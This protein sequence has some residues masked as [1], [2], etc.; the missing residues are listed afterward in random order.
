MISIFLTSLHSQ[1]G[2]TIQQPGYWAIPP[3]SSPAGMV[4]VTHASALSPQIQTQI[5]SQV[6]KIMIVVGKQAAW[7]D[8]KSV[9]TW[10]W[11]GKRIRS[12]LHVRFYILLY[13]SVV[14]LPLFFHRTTSKNFVHP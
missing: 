14:S 5:Q 4:T 10:L 7:T 6:L 9:C 11:R 13:V 12:R 2:V 1:P 3:G 8:L